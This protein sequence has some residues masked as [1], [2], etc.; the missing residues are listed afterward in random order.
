[1][2]KHL[3]ITRMNTDSRRQDAVRE[4]A[5]SGIPAALAELGALVRIPSIAFPGFDASEVQRSAEAVAALVQELAI[6]DTVE[7][8]QAAVPDSDELGHPAVLASRAALAADRRLCGRFG[9]NR[10]CG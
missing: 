9:R 3:K 5:A 1:M 2:G 6:F 7:I 8:R 4:A 10:G